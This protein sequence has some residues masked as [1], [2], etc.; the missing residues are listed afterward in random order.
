MAKIIYIVGAGGRTGAMLA[1]ELQNASEVIGV[2]RLEEA[3]MI[4]QG[5]LK[6]KRGNSNSQVFTGEI[7]TL[8]NFGEAI[9]NKYPDFIWLAI[10]NPVTE[11]VA[12]YYRYFADKDKLPVLIL[13]QNGLSAIEDARQGL[14]MALGQKAE[15][16]Q[17]VRVSLINGVDIAFDSRT[18]EIF[19]KLQIKLGFGV[20]GKV[21]PIAVDISKTLGEIFKQAGF[22]AQEFRKEGVAKW[23]RLNCLLI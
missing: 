11:A 23:R 10:R 8:E 3:E 20:V 14:K 21:D 6:I 2:C 12:A 19:Y 18:T 15:Q 13:S 22:E 1:C 4:A 7:I 16:T 5:R 17:I 9:K